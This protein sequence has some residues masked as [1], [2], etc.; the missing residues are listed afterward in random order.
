MNILIVGAGNMGTTYAKSLLASHFATPTEM[1][2]LIRSDAGRNRLPEVPD[3]NVFRTPGDFV[4]QADILIVAVKPQDFGAV[5]PGL[6]PFLHPEQIVLSIM[7]GVSI[8]TLNTT[9]GVPKLV[10]AMP[11]LPSQ[12]GMGMTVFSCSPDLDRKELFIIQNLLNTTG[13]AMYVDDERLI[14]SAT[15]VSGSGPA[16]VYY[17][18][19]AMIRAGVE[20]GFTPAQ[21]EMLVNQTFMGSVHLQNQNTLSCEEWIRRVASKGGTTE[22]ALKVFLENQVEE[23]VREAMQSAFRRSQELGK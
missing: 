7:A 4:G 21:A 13:K 22:A 23:D 8:G 2:L 15:A 5:A 19:N 14:D 16:Y 18:M 11:N 20:L 1:Q 3:Q 9:L 17:F 10:R 6:R 12:I